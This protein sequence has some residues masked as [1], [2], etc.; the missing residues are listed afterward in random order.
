MIG[1]DQL[2]MQH[3]IIFGNGFPEHKNINKVQIGKTD[4]N[5]DKFKLALGFLII[6]VNLGGY[7]ANI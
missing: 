7:T 2:Y 1:V 5:Y 4:K 3:I 6:E